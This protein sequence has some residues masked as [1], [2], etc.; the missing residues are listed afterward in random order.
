M[1]AMCGLIETVKFSDVNLHIE[2]MY[3]APA[4]MSILDL[5]I[6]Y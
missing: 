1:P 5:L 2:L 4:S 3:E 6:N